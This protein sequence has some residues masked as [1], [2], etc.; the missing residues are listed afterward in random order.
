[1]EVM[2]VF[3]CCAILHNLLIDI[4]EDIPIEWLRDI[5]NGHYWTSDYDGN[6][7]TDNIDNDRRQLVFD[8]YINDYYLN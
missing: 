8:S 5:D 2:D 6:D 7:E 3:G 1:M 4:N